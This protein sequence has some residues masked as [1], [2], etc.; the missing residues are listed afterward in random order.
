MVSHSS[1]ACRIIPA[2]AGS[3]GMVSSQTG[4]DS[5]HPRIRGEHDIITATGCRPWGSSPHTRGARGSGPSP[6]RRCGIIPAYAGSTVIDFHMHSVHRDHPRIRGEHIGKQ[7]VGAASNGSSPHT[8][9]AHPE[10][11]RRRGRR[12]II[13]AYAGSTAQ[14]HDPKGDFTDHPRI[15]GEHVI[16][17]GADLSAQGS[18]PHTRG[19]RGRTPLGRD[20]GGIIPAY[21]GSTLG[22]PCNTKDRRRDYTSFPLPVTHPSGGGGS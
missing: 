9:G 7:A 16:K 19:A 5:D 14:R 4:V 2:Y 12:R 18:S 21:A 3:T 8:R 17:I 13:P 15:R 10:C 20:A 1:A 6:D 11:H 22:N